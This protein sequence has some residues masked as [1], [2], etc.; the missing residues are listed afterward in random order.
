[1]KT[2][3][4]RFITV[5]YERTLQ[6]TLT[7]EDILPKDHL[8]HFLVDV[9]EEL[10]MDIFYAHYG[11]CGGKAYAPQILLAL[12]LYGYTTGLFSSRKIEK[13][14]HESIPFR[15]LAGGRHPDQRASCTGDG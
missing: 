6:T 13:A 11:L 12:L 3:S 7:L 10:D 5:D 8:A 15:F 1:M 9:I 4:R 14:T 2:P